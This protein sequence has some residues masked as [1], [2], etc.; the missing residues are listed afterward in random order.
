MHIF[1]RTFFVFLSL[2]ATVEAVPETKLGRTIL[3]GQDV[4]ARVEFYGGRPLVF[5]N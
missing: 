1:T 2:L 5:S 3:S 4:S